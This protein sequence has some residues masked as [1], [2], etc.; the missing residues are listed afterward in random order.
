MKTLKPLLVKLLIDWILTF[1]FYG[2]CFM[3]TF[4]FWRKMANLFRWTDII[5]MTT[6]WLIGTLTKH[7]W[8]TRYTKIN[9]RLLRETGHVL[10]DD[11]PMK[12]WERNVLIVLLVPVAALVL[13]MFFGGGCPP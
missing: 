5:P 10:M 8:D 1:A 3:L 12:P 4:F 6:G 2:L 9:N 7:Y 11:Q 13:N